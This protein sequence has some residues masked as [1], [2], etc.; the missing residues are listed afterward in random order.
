MEAALSYIKFNSFAKPRV[1][2]TGQYL[3]WHQGASRSELTGAVFFPAIVP[4]YRRLTSHWNK[5]VEY[6]LT[7]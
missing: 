1:R 2:T 4:A 5:V 6:S 3:D 7:A